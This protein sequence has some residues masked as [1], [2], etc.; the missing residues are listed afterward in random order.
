MSSK[1]DRDEEG[2]ED[3]AS[4]SEEKG[5]E[6]EEEEEGEEEEERERNPEEDEFILPPHSPSCTASADNWDDP[7]VI[8]IRDG[9][10]IR[11]PP[12]ALKSAADG[13]KREARWIIPKDN[14]KTQWKRLIEAVTM[15][16][17]Q[18]GPDDPSPLA[19]GRKIKKIPADDRA[20][21]QLIKASI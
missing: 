11:P 17:I 15:D 8:V 4:Q 21:K 10:E 19:E 1:G 2:E 7:D 13:K 9:S 14:S 5:E 18:K 3:Q 16:Y 12:K 20:I 6:E